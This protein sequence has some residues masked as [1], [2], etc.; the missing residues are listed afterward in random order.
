M[1][2]HPGFAM[3]NLQ[4]TSSTLSNAR[5]ER[6]MMSVIGRVLSQSALMGALPQL[7]AGISP[8]IH[9]GE[10]V[11]PDG[12]AEMVG[13]PRIIRS[14]AKEYD[15]PLAAKLWEASEKLTGVTSDALRAPAQITSAQS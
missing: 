12:F 4:T 7:Y 5:F 6:M 14:A 8:A 13:H 3:T 2:A 9:G 15:R 1:A 10:L 11:G